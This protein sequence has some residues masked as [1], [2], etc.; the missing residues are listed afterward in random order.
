MNTRSI[1][2]IAALA[3][4][5]AAAIVATPANASVE[6]TSVISGYSS[7]YFYYNAQPGEAFDIIIS[8]DGDSDLDLYVR[9]PG[10]NVVCRSIG[11]TDDEFCH[12]Y[13]RF[14]GRYSVQVKNRGD[15]PN[16]Y[17]LVRD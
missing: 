1:F 11:V 3:I 9:G 6:K 2:S 8:G 16:L 14:G 4:A 10:D 12:V 7:E 13:S 17:S 5:S 15:L